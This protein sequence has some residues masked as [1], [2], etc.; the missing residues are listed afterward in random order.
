MLNSRKDYLSL[1]KNIIKGTFY[2]RQKLKK[3]LILNLYMQNIKR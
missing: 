2:D 3:I 1:N